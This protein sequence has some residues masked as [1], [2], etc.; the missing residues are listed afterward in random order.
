LEPLKGMTKLSSLNLSNA[1]GITSLE[2]L[3]GLRVQIKGASDE[4][5]ATH[6]PTRRRPERKTYR[7]FII[8]EGGR[9][10]PRRGR[11]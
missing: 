4:L 11:A 5:L 8:I 2:P 9:R 10:R 1:T 7:P 3:K 6:P